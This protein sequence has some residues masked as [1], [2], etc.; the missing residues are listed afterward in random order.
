LLTLLSD[1]AQHW[2]AWRV[3]HPRHKINFGKARL[4]G[5]R[6][7][8]LN[9]SNA[10]FTGASL[11][12]CVFESTNLRGARFSRADL[13]EAMF[14][15][16]VADDAI[17]D[18][19]VF[20]WHTMFQS[21]TF[22]RTRFVGADLRN[23]KF[24]DVGLWDTLFRECTLGGAEFANAA[25]GETAFRA[26]DLASATGLDTA[27]H[28]APS[29]IDVDTLRM[30]RGLLPTAFLKG[31]GLNDFETYIAK[32]WNPDLTQQQLTDALYEVDRLRGIQ[33]IQKQSVF[34]SYSHADS[35]FVDVLQQ[36][37]DRRGIR[38]W[39]DVHDLRSGRIERQLERAIRLN[40]IVVVVLSSHS[41]ASDW[42]EWEVGQARALER[43]TNRDVL[44]PIALDDS[45]NT[46]SWSGPL[47]Q[48]ITKYHILDFQDWQSNSQFMSAVLRLVD[49]LGLF[50]RS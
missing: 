40:P 50:Y 38:S 8:H 32:I 25:F 29:S 48:Q 46:A 12:G 34:I 28:Y 49:G 24:T 35:G 44:C 15:H 39:R 2:N 14:I 3:Q 36:A 21:I 16:G 47:R 19:G 37:L 42:V 13:T 41:V 23:A 10:D 26:L 9:L 45:W 18:H 5:S 6:F 31:C 43:E 27:E 1:G 30:S 17:F 4:D 33:P 7:S 20:L 22:G 11:R